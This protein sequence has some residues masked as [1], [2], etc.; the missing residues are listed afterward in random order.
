MTSAPP[1][2]YPDASQPGNER[3]WD[4]GQ[5]SHVTRPAPGA[6]ESDPAQGGSQGQHGQPAG[7]QQ[8][9]GQYPGAQPYGQY[10]G[11]YPQAGPTAPDGTPLAGRWRRLGGWFIDGLII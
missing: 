10:P 11:A 3:W 1:G 6:Q 9:Y 5:W 8:Q 2:W 7:E 4:G